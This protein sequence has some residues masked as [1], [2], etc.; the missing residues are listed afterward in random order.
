VRAIRRLRPDVVHANGVRAGLLTGIPA[1]VTRTPLVVQVHDNLPDG[2]LGRVVRRVIDATADEV[3]AVSRSTAARFD[4]GLPRP[5]TR[6]VYIS[7]DRTRFDAASDDAATRAAL[8]VAPDAPLLGEVAQ[9]TPWKGQLEA[10]DALAGVRERHPDAVLLLIGHVAF[11]GAGVRYDN[12][13]YLESLHARVGEL[14][15]GDA[16]RFVGQRSDVPQ[17]VSALDVMLLPSWDEPFGTAALE[18]MA[19]G[20][21]PAV[22]SKGGPAEYVEHGVTGLVLEPR[23]PAI[24]GRELTALLDD[25][26]RL[27]AMGAAARR[28]S[29]RF[30]D[31]AYSAGCVAAYEAAARER[32]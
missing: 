6:T 2:P 22:G 27:A 16:V 11:A 25:R 10:I 29:E 21:V 8:G 26:E 31:A 9:I 4:E 32:G 19:S 18:A 24:W 5:R 12:H 30:T 15:L 28:A 23:D 20:T 13:A 3:I 1:R 7:F 17:L 14:G